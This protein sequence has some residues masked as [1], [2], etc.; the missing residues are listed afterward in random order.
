MDFEVTSWAKGNYRP[1]ARFANKELAIE[2]MNYCSKRYRSKFGAR[3]RTDRDR[4]RDLELAIGHYKLVYA[5]KDGD[6]EVVR[7]CT[8][9][10]QAVKDKAWELRKAEQEAADSEE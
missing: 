8:I 3:Y 1:L 9:L 7:A 4:L 10:E 5:E 2:Y 6:E